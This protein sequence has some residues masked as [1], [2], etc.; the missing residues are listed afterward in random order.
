MQTGF[1][2][3]PQ[4][5]EEVSV[6]LQ[7]NAANHV[8]QRSSKE[9]GEQQACNAEQ[10]IEQRAPHTYFD[11][12]AQLKAYAAQNQQ[13]EHDHQRQIEAAE[14]RCV[15]RGEREVERASASQEP[16]FIAVP[17]RP[18]AAERGLTLR[19]CTHEEQ[20]QH[21]H[22]EVKAVED[23]VSYD[24][25]GDQPEPDQTH[26]CQ[27]PCTSGQIQSD[28]DSAVAHSFNKTQSAGTASAAEVAS[29]PWLISR[30]IN[31][32]N[33]RPSSA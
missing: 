17:H 20:V 18:N 31:T 16:N 29:G 27:A 6:G 12:V 10:A 13:P 15:K 24:H 11:V 7:R 3:S 32:V 30:Y 19:F 23:N 14:R 26:H 21:T 2:V 1:P 25:Y 4:R 33:S 8:G 9:D 28:S 5:Q 22:A